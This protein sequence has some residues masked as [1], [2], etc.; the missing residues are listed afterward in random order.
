MNY[1]IHVNVAHIHINDNIHFT[2]IHRVLT[3]MVNYRTRF[4]SASLIKLRIVAQLLI[5]RAIDLIEK[6]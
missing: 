2:H 4:S 6:D 5:D 3:P 1:I